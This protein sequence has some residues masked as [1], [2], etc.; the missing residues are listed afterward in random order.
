ME[1]AREP[2]RIL[3][4]DPELNW[5]GGERQVLGLVE[6]LGRKGHY[7]ALLGSPG[8]ALLAAAERRGI[9]TLAARMRNELDPAGVFF[10]RGLLRSE[11]YD[12]VHFHTKR[13]HALALWL[14]RSTNGCKRV[15]TRRMDYAVK[16]GWYTSYLYNRCTDGVVAISHAIGE[17]LERAG[18]E[19]RKI[20]V[21]HSGID[22]APFA[23]A[24]ASRS[25]PRVVGT[26]AALVERKG[27]RYLLEAAAL[28]ERRG[29]RLEYRFA[30]QGPERA[31]LERHAARL[32]L[33]DRVR[34]VGFVGDI[35]GF[36]ESVD[37]FV[38]PSLYEG[39]GVAILEAMAAAR[40]VVATRVGG[41][42]EIVED[43]ATGLL[44]A[45]RDAG[46]LA[47][48]IARLAGEEGL[49]RRMGEA[50]R[51]RVRERFTIERMAQENETFYYELARGAA[52]RAPE[53]ARA[54]AE[55]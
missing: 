49:A 46:Q 23:A 9:E 7:N 17:L 52:D 30:G 35:A 32:G 45:P 42:P 40:P 6:H 11:R 18:V 20:R 25:L 4:V 29:V 37:I 54:A 50:G 48:A 53:A 55:V 12:I 21:I 1:G 24:A 10:L 3:H 44:V 5:G 13:A 51:E 33:G 27:Q 28:L 38:L 22:P 19:P 15:V 41:I 39:L 26:T 16:R 8:S 31:A 47:D 34:F 2:L 36:L 14:G 43:G